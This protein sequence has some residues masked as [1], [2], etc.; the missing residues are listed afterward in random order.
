VHTGQ[1]GTSI[2]SK[3]NADAVTIGK[4]IFFGAGKYDTTSAEGKA[5]IGHELT[6]VMQDPGAGS[7][8][9]HESEALGAEGAMRAYFKAKKDGGAAGMTHLHDGTRTAGGTKKPHAAHTD[10]QIS[11]AQGH[12][13]AFDAELHDK[14]LSEVMKLAERE[15][16][17]SRERYG[18]WR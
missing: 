5:L 3:F 1:L 4:D 16:F 7:H 12:G 10:R 18:L 6:H 11:P 8:H 13:P 15:R 14:I 17:E 9:D 2:A